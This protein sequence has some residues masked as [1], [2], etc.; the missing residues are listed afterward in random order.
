MTVHV[1]SHTMP[2][3]IFGA[4]IGHNTVLD[5]PY[6]DTVS[7]TFEQDGNNLAT[8]E[9]WLAANPFV[10]SLVNCTISPTTRYNG[11][12]FVITPTTYGIPYSCQAALTHQTNSG[13][14]TQTKTFTVRGD[15][16]AQFPTSNGLQ[17]FDAAGSITLDTDYRCVRFAGF[18]SGNVTFG[19]PVTLN[20]TGL[21]NDGTWGY[22]NVS[23]ESWSIKTTLNS[24]SITVT[25]RASGTH[26]YTIQLFR[27]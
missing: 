15:T 6:G 1:V 18:L 2:Y 22:N 20:V 16:V 21:V 25:A 12:T 4:S 17:T 11:Q 24:G 7:A 3:S 26:P 5:L 10:F 13:G 23:A 8:Q 9:A 14:T 27:D 19:T